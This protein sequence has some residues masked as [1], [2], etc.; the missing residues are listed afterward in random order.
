MYST[1]VHALL[2]GSGDH[3]SSWTS[4]PPVHARVW[5]GTYLHTS[6]MCCQDLTDSFHDTATHA[7]YTYASYRYGLRFPSYDEYLRK[8]RL[9]SQPACA[10]GSNEPTSSLP[11]FS[12]LLESVVYYSQAD[13]MAFFSSF[14][15]SVGHSIHVFS[16][17]SPYIYFLAGILFRLV[18]HPLD[19]TTAARV[20][21]TVLNSL[22]H[23]RYCDCCRYRPRYRYLPL[24]QLDDNTTHLVL[25]SDS[26]LHPLTHAL[27]RSLAHSLAHPRPIL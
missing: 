13:R 17:P 1:L 14:T 10:P 26:Y 9:G 19:D 24:Q 18:V 25:V 3:F 4:L 15:S 27:T 11:R 6:M 8:Q 22:D 12:L 2:Q 23:A 5:T 20:S 21:C 7:V 16:P